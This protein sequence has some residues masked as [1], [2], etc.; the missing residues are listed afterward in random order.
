MR[1]VAMVT[2]LYYDYDLWCSLNCKEQV[3][4]Q[5][6]YILRLKVQVR[7]RTYFQ[8][9]FSQCIKLECLPINSFTIIIVGVGDKNTKSHKVSQSGAKWLVRC[10]PFLVITPGIVFIIMSDHEI[11][12][13]LERRRRRQ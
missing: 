12:L 11:V 3:F 13:V 8:R 1:N 7:T 4:H 2:L 9:W 5:I 6:Q 10:Q